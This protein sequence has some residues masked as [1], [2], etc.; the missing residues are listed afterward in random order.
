MHKRVIEQPRD[1]RFKRKRNPIIALICEGSETEPLYFNNYKSKYIN[2]D[3]KIVSSNSKFGKKTDSINIIKKAC[4]YK[5]NN[6]DILNYKDGDRIWWIFDADIDYNNDNA[7]K[8]KSEQ[9]TKVNKIAKR[10][11]INIGIT[12][13]CFEFWY[14]LHF[15][16]STA[17][18]RNYDEV[19]N[20]LKR[21]IN[22]YQKNCD[23][24]QLL[25]D[26]TNDAIK[27][28]NI[29][30]K[31]YTELGKD[32]NN[33]EDIVACNPYTNIQDLVEYIK[34]FEI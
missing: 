34:S 17:F 25:K 32:I 24:Y 20:K 21:F 13:P 19:E 14:L 23:V 4:E 27:N 29:L 6:S 33:P 12:N 8:S 16:Y 1:K 28:A 15:E 22:R 7:V 10:N 2:I 31:Y 18:L 9:I 11:K 3:I 5:L 30:Q 26:K